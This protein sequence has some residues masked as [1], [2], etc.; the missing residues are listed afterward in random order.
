MST[1]ATL[2]VVGPL[3]AG[4]VIAGV[5]VTGIGRRLADPVALAVAVA[6]TV[7][8]VVLLVDT[9]DRTRVVW[10]GGWEPVHGQ[11]LGVALVADRPGL[12]VVCLVGLLTVAGLTYS[13]HFLADTGASYVVLV[14][15][16]LGA[17]AGF[18]LAGDVF[19]A[20]VWFELM[21]VT[22]YALTGMR[23]EE[24][25]SV[26][27]ALSFGIVNTVGASL[28]LSGVALLYARTG[29]LN[30]AAMGDALRAEP[31][32]HLVLVS[33]ALL[34]TGVLVKMALVP[35]H[36]WT[37]D[38]EAVAPTP[39]CVLLSGAMITVGAF[40]V[41]RW[42]WVVF[43][44]AVPECAF[45]HALLGFGVVT[46][47]VGAVMCAAQRHL[48]R[49]LAY[50]TV[51]HSGV[52][53]CGIG[54][55]SGPGLTAAGLYA[56]GHACTKGALFLVTGIL[57]NRFETLDE[58]ELHR[59]G[60]DMPV[61]GAVFLI[62]GLSLAGLPPLGTW[63]GKAAFGT[64]FVDA[65]VAWLELVVG[66][67]SVLTGGAV[68]RAGM[69]IFLGVGD[70][71]DPGP[72]THEEPEGDRQPRRDAWRVLVPPIVLLVVPVAIALSPEVARGSASA[73]AWMTDRTTYVDAVLHGSSGV[74]AAVPA[75][76][77]WHLSA[78]LLGLLAAVLAVGFAL[79]G[80]WPSRRPAPLAATVARLRPAVR[81]L[82]VLHRAHVGDYVSW[83]LVGFTVLG[84]ALLLG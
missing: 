18:V 9:G 76:G 42:W 83:V 61:A 48:K 24:H 4:A 81:A 71:P 25:R 39:V 29:E 79:A 80:L 22:A 49:L 12:L 3:L 78:V 30:L 13:W 34:L 69:R 37:A 77:I 38:A 63:A 65:H 58:H 23:I 57:L 7:G 36:F 17:C 31:H 35:F 14:T 59:R 10:Q 52:I 51:A 1:L 41:A 28:S 54:L 75:E 21:G 32:D 66:L 73:G 43:D 27:G 60:R 55:L 47:V 16:F 84:A 2:L 6:V 11:P 33:C 45:R 82:H 8:S 50:S 40:A 53:A 26:H 46:A 56:V 5:S 64:A 68:L 72:D 62:G 20:F 15:V 67:V 44:G 19:D 74:H 70:R